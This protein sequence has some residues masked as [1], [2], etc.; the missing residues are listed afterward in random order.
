MP[1]NRRNMLAGLAAAV[2]A[3][4]L[5]SKADYISNRDADLFRLESEFNARQNSTRPCQIAYGPL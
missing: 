1:I 3:S 2:P 4:A 5:A